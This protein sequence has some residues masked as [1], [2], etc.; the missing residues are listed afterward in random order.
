LYCVENQTYV[1]VVHMISD[2]STEQN[3]VSCC[4]KIP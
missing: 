4:C 2:V 3:M 1:T